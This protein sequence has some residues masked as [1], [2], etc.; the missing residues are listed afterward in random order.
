[1]LVSRPLYTAHIA[2]FIAA[3]AFH[4]ATA[5]A[6]LDD[7]LTFYTLSVVK[8]LF[9]ELNLV[10]V[11]LTSMCGEQALAAEL[12]VTSFALNRWFFY[13]QVQHSTL[14][15]VIRTEAKVRVF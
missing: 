4:S 2:E 9:K 14:T 8:I 13:F 1:M 12:F 10:L 5:F 11:A 3:A 15:F 7:H 6:L